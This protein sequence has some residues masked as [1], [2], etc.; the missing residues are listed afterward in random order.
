MSSSSPRL[1]VVTG[2][3][4]GIGAAIA[5]HFAKRGAEV[6]GCDIDYPAVQATAAA[7][8]SEGA[9]AHAYRLDVTDGDAWEG[10]AEGVRS[11]HGVPDVLVNNAGVFISGG[12]L[13]HDTDDWERILQ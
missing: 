11:D 6:V 8:T 7:I 5:K 9:R 4:S 3:G 13:D 12:F 2:A 10:F 1:V